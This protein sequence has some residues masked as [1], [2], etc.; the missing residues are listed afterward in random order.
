[1]GDSLK[2]YP[3]RIRN[4][5][6]RK[7]YTIK[8]LRKALHSISGV[9][10]LIFYFFP[11]QENIFVFWL[12]VLIILSLIFDALRL[13]FPH[14]NH[15]VFHRLR[16]LFVERDKHK[17]NSANFYFMG[18]LLTITLFP[19]EM[20]A[21]GILYLSVGDTFAALGGIYLKP[22][23]PFKIPKTQ[24]TFI[25]SITFILVAGGIGLLFNLPPLVA[26]ISAFVGALFEALPLGIDDNFTVPISS[27]ATIWFLT[28]TPF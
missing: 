23:V 13:A 12:S 18:C 15:F 4:K 5:P 14:I 10:A 25:G 7:P 16:F 20:A 3:E 22:F 26:W 11:N 8:F 1:M 2:D 17:I 21:I 28:Q 27:T 9:L 6:R 24:K 19:V